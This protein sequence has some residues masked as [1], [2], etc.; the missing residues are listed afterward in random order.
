MT[1]LEVPVTILLHANPLRKRWLVCQ[2]RS[3]TIHTE[4]I[5]AET[6]VLKSSAMKAWTRA[7]QRTKFLTSARIP[8]QLIKLPHDQR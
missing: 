3:G 4:V 1:F 8:P 6:F 7:A 5:Y 2:I